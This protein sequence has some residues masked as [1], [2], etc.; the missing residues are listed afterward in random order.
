MRWTLLLLAVAACDNSPEPANSSTLPDFGDPYATVGSVALE[1]DDLEVTVR[2][3][4]GCEEHSFQTR[5]RPA[6]GFTEVWLTHD[7]NGDACEA[8]ITTTASADLE[9]LDGSVVLLAPD[10]ERIPVRD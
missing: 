9:G 1:G 2:Y 10:G 4:G 3:S 6:D 5:T 8:F 7:A